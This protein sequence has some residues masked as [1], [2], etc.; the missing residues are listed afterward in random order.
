M[1]NKDV[2]KKNLTAPAQQKMRNDLDF[3]NEISKQDKKNE[4]GSTTKSN[5]I[6]NKMDKYLH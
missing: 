4:S 2:I 5:S 6:R 3:L 1:D